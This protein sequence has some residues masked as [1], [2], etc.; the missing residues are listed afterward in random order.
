MRNLELK[1]RCPNDGTLTGIHTRAV[2]SGATFL[3]AARQRDTYFN[4]PRC[5]LK[6]RESWG[7]Q[8]DAPSIVS[9]QASDTLSERESRTVTLDRAEL[10]A[11]ARPES[12]GARYSDYL[13]APVIEPEALKVALRS[14]LGIRVV[15]EKT[16]VVLL[17]GRTRIHLD[18]VADL[19]VFVELETVLEDSSE[20]AT[21]AAE[22]EHRRVI[23]LLSLA[24][25]PTVA[26]SYSDLLLAASDDHE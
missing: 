6:L 2:E 11:Y 24:S 10:I 17:Y 21:C 3:L 9:S 25:L 23:D 14:S 1:V 8:G 7:L 15:V 19:G 5:R 16:R 4:T 13:L 12:D 22:T 20:R 26:G 18:R